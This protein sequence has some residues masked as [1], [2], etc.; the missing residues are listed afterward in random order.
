M[1]AWSPTRSIWTPAFADW[2]TLSVSSRAAGR[3]RSARR[4]LGRHI[5]GAGW[6]SF[7]TMLRYKLEATGGRLVEVPAPYSSHICP[8]C[9]VVDAASRQ[10]DRF[11]CV[12]CGHEAHADL[13]AARVL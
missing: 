4:G 12:A 9:G 10:G 8:S 1:A 11:R 13:N 3:A 5:S 7:C 6:S 2:P